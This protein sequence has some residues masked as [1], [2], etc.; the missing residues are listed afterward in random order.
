MTARDGR[1]SKPPSRQRP[2]SEKKGLAR[3]GGRESDVSHLTAPRDLR[4]RFAE[5]ILLG[6]AVSSLF[7]VAARITA[8]VVGT[9]G[10]YGTGRVCGVLKYQADIEFDRHPEAV[11]QMFIFKVSQ[12]SPS[13]RR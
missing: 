1:V 9:R 7:L 6:L 2:S 8:D 12:F 3:E 13:V 10:K 4:P 11:C 5:R